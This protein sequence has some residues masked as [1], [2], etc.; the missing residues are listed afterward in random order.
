M[1]NVA[2]RPSNVVVFRFLFINFLEVCFMD[3][4]NMISNYLGVWNFNWLI[5]KLDWFICN[6]W[7]LVMWSMEYT[8]KCDLVFYR[9][10]ISRHLIQG[11]L[12]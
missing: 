11:H 2:H 10:C 6:Y 8:T 9:G 5:L 1:N 12:P 3:S 4:S 7:S